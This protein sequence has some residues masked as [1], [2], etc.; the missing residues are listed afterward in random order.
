[1]TSVPSEQ[2]LGVAVIVPLAEVPLA[3]KVPD[4]R[5]E[6]PS[7]QLKVPETV[8]FDIL[9]VT[10]SG[11]GTAAAWLLFL[12][13]A[14]SILSLVVIPNGTAVLPSALARAMLTSLETVVPTCLAWACVKWLALRLLVP[15]PPQP[16]RVAKIVKVTATDHAFMIPPSVGPW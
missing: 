4:T 3:V 6:P 11:F 2:L 15:P 5:I 13:S 10:V 1:M 8:Q 7:G 14:T 12:R 9:Q 16:A